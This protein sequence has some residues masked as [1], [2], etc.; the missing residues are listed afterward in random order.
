[1][2]I[3]RRNYFQRE[4]TVSFK[5]LQDNY[6]RDQIHESRTIQRMSESYRKRKAF[7]DDAS[8]MPDEMREQ[9][10]TYYK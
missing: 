10:N 3:D 4:A 1:M 7:K 2:E 5:E 9:L 8:V 6:E